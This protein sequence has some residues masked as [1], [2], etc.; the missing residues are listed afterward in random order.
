MQL[1]DQT[2]FECSKV[3]TQRYST[4]FTLGIKT[5][6][7]AYHLPIYAIYG[8]VRY[9]DEI[10]DTFH[11]FD[12]KSLLERFKE[13]TYRAIGEK[14]SLNPVLHSFQAV[15]NT[16]K[17]ER[18]LIDAFLHSMEMDLHETAYN[19]NGYEEYIYGSAEV[20]GLMCLRV[21]CEGNEEKYQQLRE[22]AR[23]LGAA[24]QKVNFLRDLRSDYQ[25]RGRVYFPGVDFQKFNP[26]AKTQIET[27]IQ[28]DFD[29]AYEGIKRLPS[30]AKWGVYMAYVYYKTL[31]RKIQQLPASRIMQERIRV[32]DPQKLVLWV[33]TY[34]KH[35]LNYM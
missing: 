5:L 29:A 27:D 33:Q 16:Y 17:I 25:D 15:V 20:V 30:G 12:K 32:P 35:K 28:A 26:A 3:I 23:R 1:Y 18:E 9:A 2:T 22:P 13:D 34:C 14:I 24:F 8:F 4:S 31:F 21:F 7:R 6:D 10:V 11:D 19:Q